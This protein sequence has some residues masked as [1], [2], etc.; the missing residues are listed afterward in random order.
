MRTIIK[1]IESISEFMGK[2]TRWVCVGLVAVVVYEV[3]ARYVFN[4]PTIWAFEMVGMLLCTIG[5]LGW[6]YTHLHHGHVRV[7]VFYTHLSPRGRAIIDI[8]GYLI[9]FFPLLIMLVY[10]S[11]TGAW[12]SYS[13]GERLIEGYWYPPAFPIRTVMFIGVSL[14]FL[15]GVAQFTRDLHQL[16]RNKPYD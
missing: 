12:F 4:A 5:A 16:I 10:T 15:Q 11:A 6:A 8:G 9:F 7:D 2:T 13:I 14:F 3:T 1:T